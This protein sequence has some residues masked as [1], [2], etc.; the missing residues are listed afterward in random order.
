MDYKLFEYLFKLFFD[1]LLKN[2]LL[3]ID[4]GCV[5]VGC[6]QGINAAYLKEC[7]P[8]RCDL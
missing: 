7:E 5:R 4:I 1:R 2:R 6:L 8:D 3:L